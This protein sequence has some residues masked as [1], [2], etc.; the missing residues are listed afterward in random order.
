MPILTPSHLP[1]GASGCNFGWFLHEEDERQGETNFGEP[2][3][4]LVHHPTAEA[5]MLPAYALVRSHFEKAPQEIRF[6]GLHA[7]VMRD[8]FGDFREK[9]L[10]AV[11]RGLRDEGVLET[12]PRAI[13]KDTVINLATSHTAKVAYRRAPASRQA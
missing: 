10:R 11:V 5:G 4:Y 7:K 1:E 9:H 8:M 6:A 12:A 13:S 3:D 2:H